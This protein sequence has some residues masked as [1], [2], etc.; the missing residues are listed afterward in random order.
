MAHRLFNV[1][2]ELVQTACTSYKVLFSSMGLKLSAS[3]SEV[4][5][6]TRKHERPP[7][8]VRI[9]SYVLPQT[10]FFKYMGMFFD[11][12]FRCD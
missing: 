4:M 1:T 9:G 12:I 2:C 8:L 6:F 11:A 7:I 3:K 5:L 10:T